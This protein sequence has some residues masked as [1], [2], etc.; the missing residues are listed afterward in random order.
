MS[1][2]IVVLVHMLNGNLFVEGV[3]ITRWCT[4]ELQV[5][6]ITSQH[7]EVEQLTDLANA[8]RISR[9]QTKFQ[10]DVQL[11]GLSGTS[12]LSD[13]LPTHFLTYQLISYCFS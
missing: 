4:K 5:C 2:C 13:H 10:E 6:Y 8:V 1:P 3:N 11:K 9:C 12:Y 7:Y